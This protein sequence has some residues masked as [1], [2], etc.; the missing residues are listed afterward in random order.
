ML[1]GIPAGTH[2][3]RRCGERKPNAEF[4]TSKDMRICDACMAL[5]K[6]PALVPLGNSTTAI[7]LGGPSGEGLYALIDDADAELAA[8]YH[9]CLNNGYARAHIPGS[10]SGRNGAAGHAIYLHTLLTGWA[11]VDHEDGDPMN[12]TRKNLRKA[13]QG[14]NMRNQAKRAGCSSPYKGITLIYSGTWLASV[15]VDYKVRFWQLFKDEVE[16]ARA[17]DAAAE[18]LHGEFARTNVDLGLL[19]PLT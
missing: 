14:Q 5:R 7:P 1:K 18:E 10:G 4:T 12:N 3:C 15:T 17:Y 16:A 9:W 2:K 8:G 19:P 11:R 13:T 6:P